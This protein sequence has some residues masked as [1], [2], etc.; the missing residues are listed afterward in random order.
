MDYYDEQWQRRFDA[1]QRRRELKERAVAYKGGKCILC[2]YCNP[3]GLCFHHEN[4]LE[5]EFEIS[6]KMSWE[7]IQ[8]ELDKCLLLCLNHHAEVHAGYYPQ[9]LVQD[10]EVYDDPPDRDTIPG[11]SFEVEE[12][13]P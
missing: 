11:V 4:P 6:A 10:D 8:G 12:T 9:Y 1:T 13:L 5:K 7:A 3:A 2:D